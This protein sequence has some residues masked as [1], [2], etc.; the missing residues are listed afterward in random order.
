MPDATK[1]KWML[2]TS[3]WINQQIWKNYSLQEQ[4]ENPLLL[5]FLVVLASSVPS[6]NLPSSTLELYSLLFEN[7]FTSWEAYHQSEKSFLPS[8]D[9]FFEAREVVLWGYHR[10][11]K[12]LH[13]GA[14]ESY[15][16]AAFS[17]VKR[18]L[19]DELK[20][21]NLNRK[22]KSAA[23]AE[24]I[25]RFWENVGILDR[26]KIGVT[27]W[28][29]FRHISF[30]EYGTALA[31]VEEHE[32]DIDGL[33]SVL[34]KHLYESDWASVI[35]FSIALIDDSDYFVEKLLDTDSRGS[36]Y[37][38]P[39]FLA[40]NVLIEK[41][42]IKDSLRKNILKKLET[43][44]HTH[45][46]HAIN[47]AGFISSERSISSSSINTL[48]RL[49][50]IPILMKLGFDAKVDV[51]NRL[52]I[53]NTLNSL[54]RIPEAAALVI[55]LANGMNGY[56]WRRKAPILLSNFGAAATLVGWMLITDPNPEDETEEDD[57]FG[58]N[59]FPMEDV[60]EDAVDILVSLV[61]N[62]S[63]GLGTVMKAIRAL[64]AMKQS[65]ALLSLRTKVSKEISFRIANGLEELNQI[66]DA[67][68]IWLSL[69]SDGE[70]SDVVRIDSLEKLEGCDKHLLKD[71][72]SKLERLG[73]NEVNA[74]VL[75]HINKTLGYLKS[76]MNSG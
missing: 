23:Q 7:L 47:P 10:I 28:L 20:N 59:L 34:E 41:S 48:A 44:I 30:Q 58:I 19:S 36:T 69:V 49:G 22:F 43:M 1:T 51:D 27:E 2:Q 64:V 67:V 70:A 45:P 62:E 11:A 13:L 29:A 16:N 73:K 50:E 21:E 25:I 66:E 35:Q 32:H 24:Q 38:V 37:H 8:T 40:A 60:E 26:Y 9:D 54:Q 33:W 15:K 6:L 75:N 55:S 74:R 42:T 4:A 46:K 3:N 52:D 12:H 18:L 63:A 72:S 14:G 53:A 61:Q 68:S 31:L 17:S 56:E 5:T 76:K 57:P 39:L 71:V 65:G